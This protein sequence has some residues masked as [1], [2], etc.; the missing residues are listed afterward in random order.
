LVILTSG[1]GA[2]FIQPTFGEFTVSMW[3]V[4]CIGLTGS[5]FNDA[6][7]L[8]RLTLLPLMNVCNNCLSDF[9]GIS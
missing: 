2:G 3:L 8:L 4:V 1:D 7:P 5:G 6:D 9:Q